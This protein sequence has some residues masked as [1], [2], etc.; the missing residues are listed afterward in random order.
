MLGNQRQLTPA[1]TIGR[2]TSTLGK[3][4]T[5]HFLATRSQILTIAMKGAFS[6]AMQRAAFGFLWPGRSGRMGLIGRI[7]LSGALSGLLPLCTRAATGTI[8]DVQHVV[9]FMQENRSFDHYFGSLHGVR[10][11]NDLNA[12]VFPNG[13]TDFYQPSGTNYVLPFHLTSACPNDVEHGWSDEH[14][15]WDGGKWDQWVA[16]KGAECMGYYK[17]TDLG[18]YY[19]LA[20]AYTL[21]DEY[22]CSVL[23]PTDPN[24]VCLMSGTIDPTGAGG[25]PMI[26]NSKPPGGFTWTTYPERLQDAGISWKVY[27]QGDDYFDL[28]ALRWFAQYKNAGPGN[29]LYDRGVALVSNIVAAFQADVT[30]GTLPSVSWIIPNW[31]NSEHPPFSPA[32]GA[33]LTKGLL[34]A[35]ASNPAV[36]SST[37]FILTYDEA[38][39][40]FDHVPSPVPPPGTA[41]EFVGGQPV[42]LG[43]RVPT[44][45]V[46]P[47][48]RGGYVCSEVFDHTSILRF[49]ENWTGVLE[50]NISAWRRQ[51]C[52]DL[53]SAFNFASPNTNLPSLP[54]VSRVYCSGVTPSVPN[55]QTAPVQEAG[56]NLIRPRPYK[57][58]AYSSSD[59]R[60]GE[61]AITMTNGSSTVFTPF[62][63]Y[64]NAYQ[65]DGPWQ[66]D[67]SPGSS[68][69][70]YFTPGTGG[71]YDFTCYGPHVFHRRFAGNLGND[72]DQLEAA[73]DANSDGGPFILTLQNST[74]AAVTF[75]ITNAFQASAQWTYT[76]PPGT[77]STNILFAFTNKSGPYELRASASS[78]NFFLRTFADDLDIVAAAGGPGAIDILS[79]SLSGGKLLLSY[80]A[81]AWAFTLESST[82]LSA[83]GW[84]AVN[85][86]PVLNG[87]CLVVTLPITNNLMYFRLR[88]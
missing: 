18:F 56:T 49:L 5:G 43:V 88:P 76:V 42:G 62:V 30:H 2:E 26:D 85:A 39:G 7:G 34:D 33:Y 4:P 28:N 10:G 12:L 36:Y 32:N 14:M 31:Q 21:C 84:S 11:F 52:G 57:S 60:A 15:A 50:P 22:H 72:C 58:N 79:A 65:S 47:W 70:A 55:P 77:I 29:P 40:F 73:L 66:Y 6:R 23:G 44:I 69:T 1:A 53:T 9:I 16:V 38:G 87:N 20:E 8:Q 3:G 63:I 71:L 83:G 35:L 59:C 17:R 54:P 37:V 68:V 67:V 24:R 75:V 61:L 80:P 51:I 86:T 41:N 19:A 45:I 27:Q 46:S 74:A 13:R 48:T 81:A 82:K 64:A 78:D 25:G